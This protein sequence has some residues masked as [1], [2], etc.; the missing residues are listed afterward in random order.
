MKINF[1]VYL[2]KTKKKRVLRAF[3]FYA[4]KMARKKLGLTKIT[5]IY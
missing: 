3:A 5:V 2:Y 1:L 4:E